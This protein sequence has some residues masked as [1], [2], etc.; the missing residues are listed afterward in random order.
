MPNMDY[1]D[2]T[3][4]GS[5]AA[6]MS[7]GQGL[8]SA[9][10]D[11]SKKIEEDKKR[12][13]GFDMLKQ[14]GMIKTKTEE[15]SLDELVKGLDAPAKEHGY[16]IKGINY[17]DNP[18]QA[19]KNVVAMYKALNIPLPQ[20][21]NT[22]ELN[23]TPGTKY[24][25]MKG[26]VSFEN[27]KSSV[28]M[29]QFPGLIPGN[30]NSEEN[31]F[32]AQIAGIG[33]RGARYDVDTPAEQF[34]RGSKIRDE[35]I[36]RPEVKDYVT[37]NTNVKSM[38]SL[39]SK[40]LAGDQKNK[41]ALDQGLITMYNKLTDPSSV[42][43][44]SEYARTAE[45]LPLVNRFNGAIQKIEQ[46]GAGLTDDDRKSLVWGAKVIANERGNTFN[47]ALNA[48]KSLSKDAKV[49]EKTVLRDFKEHTPYDMGVGGSNKSNSGNMQTFNI[50]GKTYNIPAD[51][52]DEFKKD[53]GL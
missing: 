28:M 3:Y 17:G 41:V 15:P 31:G 39:L 29:S 48:Y 52:V 4:K 8:E 2:T 21:K 36:N 49:S 38:D 24:D 45:N 44:E 5:M 46:G 47:E 6:G 10:G 11:F 14:F 9:A 27:P 37:V 33:S 30:S 16:T 26:D 18:E 13:M 51:Q 43:R 25:P 50:G 32:G 35:F 1:F 22:L 19:K 12:K 23:L 42:V 53:M 20:G 34:T 40:A 7:L